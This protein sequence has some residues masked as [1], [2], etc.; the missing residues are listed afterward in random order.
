MQ[1]SK[2]SFSFQ[3][4]NIENNIEVA[5]QLVMVNEKKMDRHMIR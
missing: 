5:I 3:E 1:E 2:C 4:G